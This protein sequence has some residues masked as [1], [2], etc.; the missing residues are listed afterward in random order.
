MNAISEAPQETPYPPWRRI[1]RFLRAI[2]VGVIQVA[3]SVSV[4][5][6]SI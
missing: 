2:S 1:S 4:V 5:D 6:W 3:Y